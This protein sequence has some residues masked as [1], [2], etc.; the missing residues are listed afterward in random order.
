MPYWLH[1]APAHQDADRA[2]L[3]CAAAEAAAAPYKTELREAE[4]RLQPADRLATTE[5]VRQR[6]DQLSCEEPSR[7]GTKSRDLG[8]GLEL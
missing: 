8:V 5:P 2:A 1:G 3:R 6:L 7:T 4:D